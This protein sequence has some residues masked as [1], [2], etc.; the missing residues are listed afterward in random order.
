MQTKR[1]ESIIPLKNINPP[2]KKVLL[3]HCANLTG[4]YPRLNYKKQKHIFTQEIMRHLLKECWIIM[5]RL[6]ST[7]Y[8]R[9]RILRY[10]SHRLT[11][12]IPC[13]NCYNPYS[14]PVLLLKK[15]EK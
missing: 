12:H 11:R 1:S 10:V 3:T 13:N 7:S 14:R 8:I 2:V 15:W 4:A 9:R 5:T 6:R